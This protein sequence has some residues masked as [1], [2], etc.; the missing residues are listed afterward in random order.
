MATSP[1][2]PPSPSLDELF[3]PLPAPS[4][5]GCEFIPI[6]SALDM[7]PPI[8]PPTQPTYAPIPPSCEPIFSETLDKC[9]TRG[10]SRSRS[11]S[12]SRS[13]S[14][15]PQSCRSPSLV[16]PPISPCDAPIYV[17]PPSFYDPGS[18]ACL[19]YFPGISR[20]PSPP[21]RRRRYSY[22][23]RTPSPVRLSPYPYQAP[24]IIYPPPPQPIAPVPCMSPMSPPP[25]IPSVWPSAIPPP[26]PVDILT[27]HYNNNMAYAPAPKTYDVCG[28]VYSFL[29]PRHRVSV[30]NLVCLLLASSQLIT[31]NAT[32]FFLCRRQWIM[33]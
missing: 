7:F 8:D 2:L 12:R 6:E 21:P 15:S 5:I 32:L 9:Y 13:R 10:R 30:V 23:S 17:T 4:D 18:N 16:Y 19:G 27:F 1:P 20:S 25:P 26:E 28:S 33:R 22:R 3:V 29:F 14:C 11:H 24:R 31:C